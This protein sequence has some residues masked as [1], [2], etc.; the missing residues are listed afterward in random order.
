MLLLLD[1]DVYAYRCAASCMPTKAKP[2]NESEE[3]AISRLE[4]MVQNTFK[5]INPKDFQGFLGGPLNWRKDIYPE[6]KANRDSMP[7]PEHLTVCR[8]YLIDKYEAQVCDGIEADDA[9]GIAQTAAG[10]NSIIS[11]NDKDMRT[12]PGNHHNPVTGERF[13]V[14]PFDALRYFYTQ[15]IIGDKADNIPGFDGALRSVMPKFVQKLCDPIN[16]MTSPHE[17]WDYCVGVYNNAYTDFQE[18]TAMQ[19]V[20]RNAQCLYIMRKENEYWSP[21]K[22]TEALEEIQ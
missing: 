14:S 13:F 16:E 4:I 5:T 8:Q 19:L 12:I 2:Y 17:M 1:L 7:K 3:A 20:N 22:S 10:C 15:V 9:L 6:Y 18:T 11:T 21:P